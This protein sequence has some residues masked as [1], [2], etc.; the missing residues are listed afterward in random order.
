MVKNL[1]NGS[2]NML[3]KVTSGVSSAIYFVENVVYYTN[4]LKALKVGLEAFNKELSLIEKPK[5]RNAKKSDK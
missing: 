4:Y 5:K 1:F 3:D 2:I